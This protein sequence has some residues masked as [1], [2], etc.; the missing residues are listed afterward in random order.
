MVIIRRQQVPWWVCGRGHR[1]W[2][3]RITVDTW[4]E[5]KKKTLLSLEV[6]SSYPFSERNS[7]SKIINLKMDIS[8]IQSGSVLRFISC[9]TFC[10]SSPPAS[11]TRSK[12]PTAITLS[13][14]AYFLSF[15]NDISL[16]CPISST[17]CELYSYYSYCLLCGRYDCMQAGLIIKDAIS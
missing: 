16:P 4:W 12:P 9:L 15:D 1:Q 10:H 11:D 3:Y 8:L 7:G 2:L 13:F 6:A 14:R 5:T 17:K